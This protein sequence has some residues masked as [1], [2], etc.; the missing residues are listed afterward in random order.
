MDKFNYN[1]IEETANFL[2]FKHGLIN[3]KRHVYNWVFKWDNSKRRL[4]LCNYR[5][6]VISLSKKLTPLRSIKEIE[7]TILH[8]IAH[9]L[10]FENRGK[11]EHDKDWQEIALSIGCN[12]QRC[13]TISEIQEIEFKNHYTCLDCQKIFKTHRALLRLENR[14]HPFC[15]H[16]E[17]KGHLIKIK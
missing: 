13:G 11:S 4:G 1:E 8:E 17:N 12:G 14:Y 10:D 2:L 5:Y 15:K 6:H 7:N 16:K 9:A 3:E